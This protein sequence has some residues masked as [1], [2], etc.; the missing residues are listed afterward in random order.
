M[1]KNDEGMNVNKKYKKQIE[2]SMVQDDSCN[3]C[4]Q[5]RHGD[6]TFFI[7]TGR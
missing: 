6:G 5:K 4:I 1:N 2:N 3:L 7:Y